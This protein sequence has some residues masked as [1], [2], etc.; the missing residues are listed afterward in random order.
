MSAT[1]TTFERDLAATAALTLYSLVVA[2]GFARVFSGW[3]F[4]ADLALL[5]IAGHGCSFLLRRARVS[6]WISIPAVAAVLLWLLLVIHYRAS[7]T[8]LV[9]SAVRPGISSISRSVS[10]AISSRP[11][12]HLSSTASVGRRWPGSR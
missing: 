4:L 10:S 6:G 11:L 12:S 2:V 5:S 7:M 9:P 1:R 8:W 3:D